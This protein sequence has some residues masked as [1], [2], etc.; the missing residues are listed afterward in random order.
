M[1]IELKKLNQSAFQLFELNM[2]K[3]Q[4]LIGFWLDAFFF[5]LVKVTSEQVIFH[6]IFDSKNPRSAV[7]CLIIHL[8]NHH[9]PSCLF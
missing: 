3:K 8:V 1:S 2:N 9:K 4:G 6:F 5:L 7:F